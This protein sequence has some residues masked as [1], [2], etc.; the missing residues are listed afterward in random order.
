MTQDLFHQNSMPR[1]GCKAHSTQRHNAHRNLHRLCFRSEK[2]DGALNAV[3][4][5]ILNLSALQPLHAQSS[6][7]LLPP[8]PFVCQEMVHVFAEI[9]TGLKLNGRQNHLASLDRSSARGEKIG[10]PFPGSDLASSGW[11][12]GHSLAQEIINRRVSFCLF[13][14]LAKPTSRGQ[15]LLAELWI[16]NLTFVIHT[17]MISVCS[18]DVQHSTNWKRCFCGWSEP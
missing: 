15:V 12:P 11:K 7:M 8:E 10:P 1:H 13:F 14:P 17:T 3:V 9:T 2:S 6:E 18:L 5:G 4:C 16:D